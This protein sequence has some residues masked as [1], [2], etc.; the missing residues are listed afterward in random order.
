MVV[1]AEPLMTTAWETIRSR[2]TLPLGL[3]NPKTILQCQA[4]EE[5]TTHVVMLP[6]SASPLSIFLLLLVI[7]DRISPVLSMRADKQKEPDP[8]CTVT[9]PST[10][11]FFDLRPLIRRESDKFRPNSRLSDNRTDWEINGRDYGHN[12]TL[13]ICEPVLSDYSD[14]VGVSDHTNVS[15]FYIDSNG[16]KISI[17]L[18][19]WAIKLLTVVGQ[20]SI[21]SLEEDDCYWNIKMARNVKRI[22][23]EQLSFPFSAIEILKK[24]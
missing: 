2:E 13:N 14:V 21:R 8:E 19:D 11:E 24:P 3:Q 22:S 1:E 15:A 10:G 18:L 16:R 6:S 23:I 5:T 9:N 4:I 12:F 17:G 7:F 20:A